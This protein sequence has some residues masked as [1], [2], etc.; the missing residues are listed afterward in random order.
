M[1]YRYL[2]YKELDLLQED[3]SEFLYQ[4]GINQ[5]EWQVLQDQQSADALYLL[6]K[7]S[8][9]TFEKVMH[10]IHYLTFRSANKIMAFQCEP[11]KMIVLSLKSNSPISMDRIANIGLLED[12]K[13]MLLSYK[14]GKEIRSYSEDRECDIFRL[15]EGGCFP[16]DSSLFNSL[17]LIRKSF[18]N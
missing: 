4:E 2:T 16:S 1:K 15:I 10:D 8:D 9:L 5:F 17:N 7:Y 12:N 6:E 14:C 11:K 13:E 18:Q 3:F